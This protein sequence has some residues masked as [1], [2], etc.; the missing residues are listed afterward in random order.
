M[1]AAFLAIGL[2]A[3]LA[4]GAAIARGHRGSHGF[5]VHAPRG[6]HVAA[7]HMRASGLHVRSGGTSRGS[8]GGI[9]RVRESR[10]VAIMLHSF[11][12]IVH[13]AKRATHLRRKTY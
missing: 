8:S 3:M 13:A 12:A 9:G 4:S 10:N 11:G 7:L 1:K 5:S 6:F 2:A